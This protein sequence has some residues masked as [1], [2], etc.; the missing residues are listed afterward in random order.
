MKSCKKF[1]EFIIIMPFAKSMNENRGVKN[2]AE[3][4]EKN[5]TKACT[6]F[7]Y[8]KETLYSRI[9]MLE[10][11]IEKQKETERIYQECAKFKIIGDVLIGMTTFLFAEMLHRIIPNDNNKPFI[12]LGGSLGFLA[13]FKIP[14]F[15]MQNSSDE[16][17][18][19][20]QSCQ[21]MKS[22]IAMLDKFIKKS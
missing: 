17:L 7:L 4:L 5:N 6:E 18:L 12:V 22:V 19:L 2:F 8:L 3:K 16:D 21:D 13:L 11:K 10:R 14:P 9:R 1:Q 15:F 20:E